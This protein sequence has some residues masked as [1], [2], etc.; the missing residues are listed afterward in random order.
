MK[1]KSGLCWQFSTRLVYV[2][3][4]NLKSY[5]RS[6]LEPRLVDESQET[7]EA[8]VAARRDEYRDRLNVI[9]N[10]LLAKH[11]LQLGL[12]EVL[13]HASGVAADAVR[14]KSPKRS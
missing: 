6:R 1:L 9:V 5:I 2:E 12:N 11:G 10:E 8:Y 3:H 13:Y 14:S 4:I 7:R